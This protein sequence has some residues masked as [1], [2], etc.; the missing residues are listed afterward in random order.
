MLARLICTMPDSAWR[1]NLNGISIS[2][3]KNR[4]VQPVSGI[5]GFLHDS[6][7][8]IEGILP[9]DRTEGLVAEHIDACGHAAHASSGIEDSLGYISADRKPAPRPYYKIPD[10][11]AR[12][13][14]AFTIHVD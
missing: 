2:W 11:Q 7:G 4:E 8:I 12:G 10:Q 13:A 1:A 6:L 5:G 9:G 14:G 3:A